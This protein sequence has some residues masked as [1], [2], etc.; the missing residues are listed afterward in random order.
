MSQKSFIN[1]DWSKF[2][3]PSGEENL[4]N[5]NNYTIKL[6]KPTLGIFLMFIVLL[7]YKIYL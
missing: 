4:S 7:Y 2:L 6:V 3:V 5:L 1:I